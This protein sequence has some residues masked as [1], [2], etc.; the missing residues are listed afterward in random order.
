MMA[1][2]MG[3]P[4]ARATA[5]VDVNAASKFTFGLTL[6]STGMASLQ[7]LGGRNAVTETSGD[8]ASRAHT[9]PE[10]KMMMLRHG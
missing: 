5:I 6:S 3:K 10:G 1:T 2:A 8:G 7:Q 9:C 4:S